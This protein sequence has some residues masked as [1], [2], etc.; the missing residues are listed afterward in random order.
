MTPSPTLIRD[1]WRR[2][3]HFL[4]GDIFLAIALSL[5]ALLL[6]A[7][8]RLPQTPQN[9]PIAYSRWLSDTQ[10]RF[11]GLNGL[12]TSLGLFSIFNSLVFRLGLGGLGLNA[13]LRL[14]DQIEQLRARD[15]LP[16]R[17]AR[18]AIDHTLDLDLDHIRLKLRGYRVRSHADL[19]VADH[20]PRSALAS[21]TL[22]GA[23]LIVLAG[24]LIG[25]FA[26]YRFDNLNVDLPQ[27]TAVSGTPYAI[28]LD[29][30]NE[31]F[32]QATVTLLQQ[33]TSLLQSTLS[34]S[35]PAIRSNPAVYLDR[36]GPALIIS[37]A[38]E[39]GKPI[40][41]QTTA[42]TPA[43][44]EKSIS[45]NRDHPEG[46]IAAPDAGLVLQINPVAETIETDYA[47]QAYQT[48][49]GKVLTNT[50]LPANATLIVNQT[51]FNFHPSAFITVSL[52]SQPSHYVICFGLLLVLLGLIGQMIWRPRHLWLH[53]EADH[54]RLISDDPTFD[55]AQLGSMWHATHPSLWIVFAVWIIATV[56]VSVLTIIAYQRSASIASISP[57]LIGLWLAFS[58][59]LIANRRTRIVLIVIGVLATFIALFYL[60]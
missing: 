11:G 53:T 33:D 28:R 12:F 1:P 55:P 23:I 50:T 44:P 10:Q 49:S 9:D 16:D 2:S 47:I 21:I 36:I 22:Y 35:A 8:A 57:A 26:D 59:S 7:A 15:V 17:P 19:L 41:L 29:S 52:V 3:W 30:L 60:I 40:G 38:D 37:A 32:D 31:T 18:P 14:I 5:S 24:L 34:S 27:T 48:A 51:I 6:I 4:S 45:F 54:S 20:L 43:Q 56:L 13:A 42:D 46:F 58:G 39:A 25:S